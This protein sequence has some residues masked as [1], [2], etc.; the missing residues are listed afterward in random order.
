VPPLV[1]RFGSTAT[2]QAAT[3]FI[4]RRR[5]GSRH[6]GYVNTTGVPAGL[7][8]SPAASHFRVTIARFLDYLTAGFSIDNAISI[9][10]RVVRAS[11]LRPRT[12]GRGCG[13]RR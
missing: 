7:G 9:A 5:S 10:D 3:V 12:R 4:E 13:A 6:G 8:A 1:R 2:R 11:L